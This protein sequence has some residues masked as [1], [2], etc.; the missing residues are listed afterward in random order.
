MF[1]KNGGGNDNLYGFSI[2]NGLTEIFNDNTRCRCAGNI[3]LD[4]KLI[5]P[6]QDDTGLYGNQM[7]FSEIEN[8]D[9]NGFKEKVFLTVLPPSAEGSANDLK[10]SLTNNTKNLKYIGVH[11][12]NSNEDYE[13]I[14]L[15]AE[16][17]LNLFAFWN[18]R[19][20]LFKKY[21]NK[22]KGRKSL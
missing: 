22:I 2:Q 7:Y 1:D 4:E 5:R 15:L 3:I 9:I 17:Q 16:T 8:D 11:T 14:D 19:N 12:Y 13:V 21:T 6:I 18:N 10:I 20:K